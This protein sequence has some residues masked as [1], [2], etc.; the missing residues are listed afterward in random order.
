[1]RGRRLTEPVSIKP[2]TIAVA[3]WTPCAPDCGRYRA[4]R[5]ARQI[6]QR[7]FGDA[8]VAKTARRLTAKQSW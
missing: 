7:P 4:P 8:Q 2:Q 6:P 1:L 5:A 3:P